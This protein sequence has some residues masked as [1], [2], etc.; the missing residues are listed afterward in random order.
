MI[1]RFLPLACAAALLPLAAQAGDLGQIGGLAQGQ[2]RA[3][4][5]DIGAAASYKGLTPAATLG[6]LGV[7]AG[8][9]LSQTRIENTNVFA[10]AGAGSVSNL[11]TTKLHVSKGLP[12]GVDLGAFVGKMSGLDGQL[13]GAE[14]RYSL[15][16]EG[17]ATPGFALRAS[18]S[19]LSGVDRLSLSTVALDAMIAKKLALVTPYAGAGSVRVTARADAP[20]LRE[21]RFNRGRVFV[22]VNAN[23]LLANIAVEAEQVGDNSSISAKVGFRF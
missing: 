18:G 8:L 20:G 11:Y 22:G 14:A 10:R 21:E 7:D 3:L 1:R 6:A 9:E 16:D 2:F 19:R 13:I 15:V 12:F 4:S 23:L 5:E 17:M